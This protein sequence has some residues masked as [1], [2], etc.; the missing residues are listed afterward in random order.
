[1]LSLNCLYFLFY[2]LLLSGAVDLLGSMAYCAPKQLSAC[3]PSIVPKITEVL[4]DSHARVEKAGSQALKQ[5]G[6]VIRN[7]EIQGWF[8][9]LFS[10]KSGPPIDFKL[11]K[12]LSFGKT[13]T[14]EEESI[15]Y[16][17]MVNIKSPLANFCHYLVRVNVNMFCC[18][19]QAIVNI[20]CFC[21]DVMFIV[22]QVRCSKCDK[23][24]D[25]CSVP[26]CSVLF[27]RHQC[28]KE[29]IVHT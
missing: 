12:S 9:F 7:P 10:Q 4:T 27:L 13:F 1:M 18:L 14:P 19:S 2:I 20:L 6:S 22:D 15:I 16:S 3:L 21:F 29:I 28:N 24:I 17:N 11:M 23:N 26:S 25:F 8:Q 5:I